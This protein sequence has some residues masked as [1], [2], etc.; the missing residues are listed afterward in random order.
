MMKK[1]GEPFRLGF[2][3]LFI[4]L[5]ISLFNEKRQKALAQVINISLGL[6]MDLKI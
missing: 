6:K 2:T 5:A 4:F 3:T 1:R